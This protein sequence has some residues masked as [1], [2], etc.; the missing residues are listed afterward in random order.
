MI[1]IH[2]VILLVIVGVACLAAYFFGTDQ[3]RA[4]ADR[5]WGDIIDD[6]L[7]HPPVLTTGVARPRSPIPHVEVKPE[8]RKVLYIGEPAGLNKLVQ[9][10]AF[11]KANIEH[12]H[13]PHDLLEQ[14]K[15]VLVVVES[16]PHLN[17]NK[18][19]KGIY[20]KAVVLFPDSVTQLSEL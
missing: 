13:S 6:Y 2:I 3:G 4:A 10:T 17:S 16:I 5:H 14:G 12:I 20:E 7:K 9:L 15:R 11:R 1:T 19:L 8:T 18:H